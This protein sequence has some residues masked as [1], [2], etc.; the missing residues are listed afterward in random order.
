MRLLQQRYQTQPDFMHGDIFIDDTLQTNCLEDE[1]RETKVPGETAIPAGIYD[2]ELYWSPTFSPNLKRRPDYPNGRHVLLYKDVTGFS[3]VEMHPGNDDD[4][5]RGC[6]LPG[7]RESLD[8]N[9]V[10]DSKVAFHALMDK[11]QPVLERG[12]RVQIEVRN[13]I[14]DRYVDTG[15]KVVA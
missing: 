7:R 3:Y 9:W 5:T 4:D 1:Q 15:N 13:A 2:L 14:E 8:K 6:V 11:V 12:E 10:A